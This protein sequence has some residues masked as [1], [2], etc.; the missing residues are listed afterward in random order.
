VIEIDRRDDTADSPDWIRPGEFDIG[1]GMGARVRFAVYRSTADHA[2]HRLTYDEMTSAGP[3]LTAVLTE[4][5]SEREEWHPA[6]E[7]DGLRP[8]VESEARA[9]MRE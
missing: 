9:I 1:I 5:S 8:R 7:K 6:W 3:R 4:P 2:L